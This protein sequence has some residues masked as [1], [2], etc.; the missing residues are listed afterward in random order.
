VAKKKNKKKEKKIVEVIKV[1]DKGGNAPAN[2]GASRNVGNAGT[3]NDD[4]T[5]SFEGT[6]SKGS[7]LFNRLRIWPS[8]LNTTVDTPGAVRRLPGLFSDLG[9][10]DIPTPSVH[11][12]LAA[13]SDPW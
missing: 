3:I 4:L 13:E 5:F 8:R 7:I 6:I 2:P 12:T 9:Y 11:A 10:L 1:I